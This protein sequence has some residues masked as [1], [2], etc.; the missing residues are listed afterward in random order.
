M[1]KFT[2][3]LAGWKHPITIEC[4]RY[5]S[6]R[7]MQNTIYRLY[8]MKDDYTAFCYSWFNPSTGFNFELFF[9]ACDHHVFH[10][11]HEVAHAVLFI[12]QHMKITEEQYADLI[13]QLTCQ[14]H[15]WSLDLYQTECTIY[16]K[17]G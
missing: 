12:R 15:V 6:R 7:T 10:I 3:T 16:H 9:N 2:I 1:R 4:F 8:N 13:G 14:I 5:A 11:A 17:G